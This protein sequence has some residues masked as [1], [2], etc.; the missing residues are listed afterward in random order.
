MIDLKS[1]KNMD[2]VGRRV[3]KITFSFANAEDFRP[4]TSS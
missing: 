4:L 1:K 2:S 3:E